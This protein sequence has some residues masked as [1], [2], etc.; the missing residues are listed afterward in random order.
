M[1]PAMTF[2]CT[3]GVAVTPS[4]RTLRAEL[5]RLCARIGYSPPISL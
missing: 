5:L 2:V 3:F 1:A 4:P